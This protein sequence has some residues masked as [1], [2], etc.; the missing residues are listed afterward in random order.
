MTAVA[1]LKIGTRL[2]I[3]FAA[4]IGLLVILAVIGVSRINAVNANTE[5][6]LHDRFGK[7]KLAQTVENEVNKQLRAIRTAMIV[8][9]PGVSEKELAKIE[10]SLP[11]VGAAID[12]LSATVHSEIGKAALKKL[13]E[14]RADF[15]DKE[16]KLVELIRGGKIDEGRAM[17]VSDILPLQGAYLD[18]V[19]GFV[20]SQADGMEQFGAEAGEMAHG[21]RLMMMSLSVIAVILS[22]AIA[23][24]LTRSITQPI[25]QA[26]RLAQTVAAGDLTSTVEVR[27][28][29]EAGQLLSA[30]ASMN[31]SLVNIV[32]QVRLS[33]DSIATGSQ[34]IATG[35]ADL[36]HRTEEQASNLEETASAMEELAATVQRS[37]ASARDATSLA[38]SASTVATE[39][40]AVVARVI[41]TM[42][43]ISASS[44]KIAE[45]T[46]VI[47]GIAFQTNI[48]ALNAAVEAARAGEQGRGFAVVASEVRTLAQRA[49]NAAK[50]IKVLIG[51]SV[52]RVEAGADL[53]QSAGSTMDE[54]VRQVR[55]VSQLMTEIGTAA[56]QQSLGIGEIGRA[57][58]QLDS[59]TQQNAAL[60]EESAAAAD[61]L[62]HQARR[63]TEIV[64]TFKVTQ[65]R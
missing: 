52:S 40:G 2:A 50:D 30:L 38:A 39:G 19:E 47:D 32:S 42:S 22:V 10:T 6:I 25:S 57:V 56:G 45:I 15:K 1:N 60:V 7:V 14:S 36:S 17:L 23:F 3:G 62:S 63:L 58:S 43:D 13:I 44:R 37:A 21:A 46:G 29:D 51:E 24:L 31:A 9:D 4:V 59:V 53:V 8:T 35:S 18:A 48:L 5:L 55:Q 28:A 54:I 27:R 34:Q 11:I 12:T 20:K 26:V 16:R 41:S 33:S 65:A 64:G 61:S 49:A